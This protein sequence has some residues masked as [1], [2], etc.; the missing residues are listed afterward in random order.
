VK[1]TEGKS[2]KDLQL[3]RDAV[4]HMIT[5]VGGYTKEQIDSIGGEP[6]HVLHG[7][8]IGLTIVN[9]PMDVL[10]MDDLALVIACT[11]ILEPTWD[12]IGPLA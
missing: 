8:Y 3:F 12:D 4:K 7:L 10:L 5:D 1:N 9:D 11:E 2:E 6:I